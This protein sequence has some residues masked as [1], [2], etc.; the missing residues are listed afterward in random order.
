MK[1]SCPKCG[2]HYDVDQ[3]Y[4]GYSIDCDTC[5]T[6]FLVTQSRVVRPTRIPFHPAHKTTKEQQPETATS[7]DKSVNLQREA[8][9][10]H[11]SS[12]P[13]IKPLVCEMCGSSEL[14]KTDG[15]F[16]CQSCGTRYTAEEA[17]KMMTDGTVNVIGT[18]KVDISEKLKN[19]YKVARRAKEQGNNTQAAKYYDLILQEDANSWEANFYTAYFKVAGCSAADI[20]ENIR[21]LKNSVK[22]VASIIFEEVKNEEE[23][24]NA[25]EE[26]SARLTYIGNLFYAANKN[27][28]DHFNYSSDENPIDALIDHLQDKKQYRA[29]ATEISAMF[30]TLGDALESNYKQ[31][32]MAINIDT[33]AKLWDQGVKI[34]GISGTCSETQQDYIIKIKQYY[35][36]ANYAKLA[37]E[38]N[39]GCYIATSIYGSYDCPEVWTLR[40]FRDNSLASTW[41]GKT[42]ISLY[43]TISPRLVENFGSSQCFQRFWRYWLD[44]LVRKLQSKGV[45]SSPYDD[46]INPVR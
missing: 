23:R 22:N 40:R 1:V 41:F 20:F 17:K 32:D 3:E 10:I 38:T 42:F 36:N 18:V 46:P 43:Y 39:S 5:G 35:P 44:K 8:S 7:S 2:Q 33:F 14:V 19:L 27:I 16:I 30:Y 34:N 25:Y 28:F 6:Q 13:T 15:V 29:N 12:S 9:V 37:V 21:L 11:Q 31:G 45:K 26:I 24:E 4:M